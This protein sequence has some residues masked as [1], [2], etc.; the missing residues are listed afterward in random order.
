MPA[1]SSPA[2]ATEHA[3]WHTLSA[4]ETT[5]AQDVDARTGLA[6]SAV[7]DR[8][9][10]YGPN[11]LRKPKR[12]PTWRKIVRLLAEKM[13]IVLLVAAVVSAVVSREL[14]TPIVILAVIILNTV[15]N[16]VQERRAESSLQ[17]LQKLSEG[18]AV[19]R[20][21]GT[22]LE[23]QFSELVPGD[24]VLLDA[25]DSVPADGRVIDVAG[26][27]VA[28]A[29]LTG[30]SEPVGKTIP[31]LDNAGLPLADRTNM[32]FMNTLVTRGRA[33]MVV[34]DTG[35]GTAVGG[36]AVLLN[37]VKNDKTPLQRRID[38]LAQL[39]TIAALVVVAIV[40]VLGL[41]RGES[42][43]ELLIT[44]VSL[45]VATIPEG[46]TAVVAFTLAMGASRLAAQGAIIKQ[47]S[48]VETLG[49]VSHIATD[50]TGTLTMNEMTARRLHTHG[51]DFRITGEGYSTDG[52]IL[53]ADDAPMPD[54]T[55]AF[56]TMALCNDAVL[57]DGVL[58]GDPTEGA[59]AVLAE[60]GG[61]DVAGARRTHPRVAE[62]P[63]DSDYKFM[64][65]FHRPA[66]PTSGL[67]QPGHRCFAKGAP[68][69]LLPLTDSVLTDD[70]LRPL[71]DTLRQR[72]HDTIQE[73]AGD[74]LRTIMIAGRTLDAGTVPGED[75]GRSL[76]T[77]LTLYAIVGIV[78]P[79][80]VEAAEAIS[81]ALGAGIRVHM[82]TGDHLV[83][84]SAIARNLGLPGEAAAGATLDDLD[85]HELAV[86]AADYGVLARVTPAHKIRVVRALQAGGDVVAMT[87]D[88]V[89]DA[90]A[91]KQADIGI[92]MGITGTDVSK[93]AANMIL[94]DDNFS[95]I[96]SAVREGRGI[97]ANIL[98]FVRFQ[99]TTA[100]GFVL[101]FLIAGVTGWAAGA[102]FTALQILW[103]NIIMD[104]PPAL[105]LGLDPAEPGTM[106]R[107]PRPSDEP[108]ITRDRML[109]ILGLGLV[110][111]AG[112]LTVLTQA[113]PLFPE[114]AG[115]P[116]FATTLA[117]TTF[118][119]YQVFNLLNVRSDT[120]SVFSLQTFTNRSI[121]LALTAVIVLQILV[122][123]ID[124][125]QALF[126]TTAL[127]PTQW[128]LCVLVG[129]SVLWIEEIR[130][131]IVR[132]TGR[133][134]ARR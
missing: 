44:A 69:A 132:A 131:A 75:S 134:A 107:P 88:G 17:A 61:I 47:L 85:D 71:D 92:A 118:V 133:R 104:G 128:G 126:D 94:T 35:M 100:W 24:I 3:A 72:I 110:M 50:K 21:G 124:V 86:Y 120:H 73:L 62:V 58:V 70:G 91:L 25:G 109:R 2:E 43:T 41:L 49:S 81:V 26:L 57:H 10:R 32:L 89:N 13:T 54:L 67:P 40:F 38:Q 127:T 60:K 7:D 84:A 34:T 1:T 9:R 108:L 125:L 90:P 65:T 8:R 80:R 130:K 129:S 83:T 59:L 122:V 74:G 112:T 36:I 53:T 15:L 51:R 95:T 30:E 52:R 77:G 27:Q 4:A 19:V 64:A 55:E 96:V 114:S 14:E 103:V 117:F 46:L 39:L 93:G 45:A 22:E 33:T 31:A 28:E 79:P 106:S 111:A 20:R 18:R 82:I 66:E 11:L 6:A 99:L 105:A 101:I 29:A 121:W 5:T 97:Y 87:G 115:N 23:V 42:W 37:E 56:L 102:P 12:V 119:F 123:Q 48:A 98:K 16:Y 68:G 78:D 113:S 76:V 63:F 116:A